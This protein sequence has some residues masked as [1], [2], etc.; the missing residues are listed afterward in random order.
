MRLYR[1]IDALDARRV[2][3]ALAGGYAV[4]LYGALRGTVGLD[5]VL[6]LTRE[7]FV[8]A[9]E[10]LESIGLES[11]LPVDAGLV[12]DFRKEFVKNRKLSSWSFWNP[13]DAGERVDLMLTDDLG[14]MGIRKIR[15]AGRWLRLVEP[16]DLIAMKTRR[17]RPQDLEDIRALREV[18]P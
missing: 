16:S 15:C 5:L 9:Q 11:R 7:N 14:G 4:A 10:A 13:T 12:F 2:D 8:A 6:R 18:L 3:Y 1:V 17:A